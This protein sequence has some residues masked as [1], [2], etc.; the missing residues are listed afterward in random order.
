MMTWLLLTFLGLA[1]IAGGVLYWSYLQSGSPTGALFGPRPEKRLAI[2]EHASV[3][4]RRRLILLRRDGV[5][6]LIMTGGPVDVVIETGISAQ[7]SMAPAQIGVRPKPMLAADQ[8]KDPPTLA[9]PPR[10][11]GQ[12]AGE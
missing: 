1:A 3:D 10:S 12:A 4:G 2:V 5:E 11:F 6:H 8:D 7:A 9:R